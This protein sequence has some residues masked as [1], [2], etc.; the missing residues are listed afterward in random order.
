MTPRLYSHRSAVKK[1]LG[2]LR[3]AKVD[4]EI[5]L[6]LAK[7]EVAETDYEYID[8]TYNLAGIEAMLGNREEA[9]RYVAELS[10]LGATYRIPGHLNDYFSSLREDPE[11]QDLLNAG[12]SRL[13]TPTHLAK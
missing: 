13:R 7:T 2:R 12:Q 4:A 11:F 6:N 1:R 10:R 5:A 9:P 8:A 3:E